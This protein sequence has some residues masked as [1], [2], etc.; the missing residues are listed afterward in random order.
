MSTKYRTLF[1]P[2]E[3]KTDRNSALVG[4]PVLVERD[5]HEGR[6]QENGPECIQTMHWGEQRRV[7]GWTVL[8]SWGLGVG[9]SVSKG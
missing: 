4:L 9:E 8:G 2:L 6:I 3:S 5:R 7:T 1:W